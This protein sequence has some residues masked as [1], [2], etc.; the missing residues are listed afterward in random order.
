MKKIIA[1]I[2]VLAALFALTACGKFKCDICGQ[3]KSGDKHEVEILGRTLTVC[4]DC[5]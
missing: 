5:A 4:D 1:V 2:C 3:E